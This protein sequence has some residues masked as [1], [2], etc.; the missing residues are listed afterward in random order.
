MNQSVHMGGLPPI[1]WG[2]K[3][4]KFHA[5]HPSKIFDY[6][7]TSKVSHLPFCSVVQ[8]KSNVGLWMQLF[9]EPF[10]VTTELSLPP[11][12][13][14]WIRA[15]SI[16]IPFCFVK[17]YDAASCRELIWN[18]LACRSGKK[19]IG[20]PNGKS[21]SGPNDPLKSLTGW[22]GETSLMEGRGNTVD[23]TLQYTI[24]FKT[25]ITFLN[26]YRCIY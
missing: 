17:A 3:T 6:L 12:Q 20:R 24:N 4:K 7:G 2:G 19:G 23:L 22:I 26:L 13:Y 15:N 18:F 16:S 25:S 9:F 11:I 1:D 21:I 10:D 5:R 8:S 14:A